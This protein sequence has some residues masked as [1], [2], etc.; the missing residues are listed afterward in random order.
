M[1][2]LPALSSLPPEAKDALIWL[3]WEKYQ[4]MSQRVEQFSHSLAELEK[5]PAKTSKNSSKPPSEGFKPNKQTPKN[6]CDD[7]RRLLSSSCGDDP[8]GATRT[9]VRH[10]VGDGFYSKLK[11]VDGVLALVLD[12][13]GKLRCDANLQDFG[14][15]PS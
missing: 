12:V 3:L 6:G 1:Q 2:E 15:I 10:L 5:R 4:E 13:I 7:S 9:S 14:Q 8:S 11:R